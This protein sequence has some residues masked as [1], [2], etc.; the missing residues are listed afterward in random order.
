MI[1]IPIRRTQRDLADPVYD[2]TSLIENNVIFDNEGRGVHVYFSDRVLVRNNTAYHNLKDL[3]IA[4]RKNL[5]LHSQMMSGLLIISQRRANTPFLASRM[6]KRAASFGT[7]IS[8]KAGRR[9]REQI[10]QNIRAAI[11]YS[12]SPATISPRP[13]SIRGGRISVCGKAVAR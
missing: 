4:W 10:R 2:G 8:S 11:I 7:S 12:I 6:L 9:L 13:R 1:D 3:N 5:W